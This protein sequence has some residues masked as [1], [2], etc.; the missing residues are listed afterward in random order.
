MIITDTCEAI[1]APM[2]GAGT[3][4][5]MGKI[6]PSVEARQKGVPWRQWGPYLSERQW[7][8]VRED[9]APTASS[10][11]ASAVFTGS[12]LAVWP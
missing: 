6:I 5:I 7:G 4:L 10:R 2:I 9:Y 1:L 3:G 8:T 11:S 12:I